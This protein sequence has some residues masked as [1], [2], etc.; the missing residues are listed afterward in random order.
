MTRAS[1]TMHDLAGAYALHALPEI[2]A[3]QF[4][5]HLAECGTC[6]RE[7]R[8]LRATAARLGTAAARTAPLQLRDRVLTEISRTPQVRPW[9]AGIRRRGGRVFPPRLLALAAAACLLVAVALG[10]VTVRTQDR[11]D[12]VE[13]RQRQVE[14]VLTAPDAR[15]VTAAVRTGGRGTV[16]VSRRE[17]RA[18][19]IMTGLPAAPPSRTYELWLLGA[20]A[21]RPAGL[22]DTGSGPIVVDGIGAAAGIG[23]TV[24]PEGGSPEPTTDPVFAA[25]LPA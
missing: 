11:L 23:I 15:T 9:A 20:G 17:N 12:R 21:P 16:V 10:V 24:E 6:A 8:G 2:E 19:V 4:E 25:A 3:R 7:M 22:T 13:A 5:A 1:E 14:S 18:V